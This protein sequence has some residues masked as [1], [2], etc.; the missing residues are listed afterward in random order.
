MSTAPPPPDS[1]AAYEQAAANRRLT[2][3]AGEYGW[4]LLGKTIAL[5]RDPVAMFADH[6]RRYGDI[7]RISITGQKAVMLVGPELLKEL[8]LDTGRNYST[9]MGWGVFM[10]DFFAGGVLMRDFEEHRQHRRI[11]QGAFKSEAMALYVDQL[12]A[13]VKTHVAE[14]GRRGQIVF[15]EETKKLLLHIAFE[16]FCKTG[17]SDA[18]ESEVN[19]AFIDMMEGT[20]GMVRKD[21]PG[22]L[23]RR[24]MDGRRF[25]ERY[26]MRCVAEKRRGHDNDILSYF[27]RETRENGEFFT[28]ADI[29]NHMI[30]LMLAAHDTT[31]SAITMA[32]YHLTHHPDWQSRLAAESR[33]LGHAQPDY[34]DMQTRMPATGQVFHEVLRL[35]PPVSIVFRRS[36]RDCEIR[37]VHIPAHTMLMAPLIYNHQLAEWWREPERFDPSRFAG[38]DP[39]QRQ[40]PFLW[41]PFG[42]GAHKCIGMHFADLLFKSTF[43][44]L[45]KQYDLQYVTTDYYPAPLQYFPFVKP[46]DDLPLR[47]VRRTTDGC[48]E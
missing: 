16:V 46:M 31:T 29:A 20:M 32:A 27:C 18:E 33:Q 43:A 44:E 37:G 9:K 47:L 10:S 24:G 25:L 5:F 2:H 17:Q 1:V 39:G 38:P 26:F 14:W 41:A 8:F 42:G 4:P 12:N 13:I 36:I 19:Q 7:S 48:P 11:M 23:Y 6:H 15:Y 34:T 3:I 28:D 45:L 22:L 21:W 30:F 40:H 35:Y